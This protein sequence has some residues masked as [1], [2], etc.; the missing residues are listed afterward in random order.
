MTEKT[1]KNEHAFK[2]EHAEWQTEIAERHM[3]IERRA[4]Q[5]EETVAAS[6]SMLLAAAMAGRGGGLTAEEKAEARLEKL[7]AENRQFLLTGVPEEKWP[8]PNRA[9][10]LKEQNYE[11]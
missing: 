6:L 4:V 7:R 11:I 3:E 2:K 10:Y 8:S 1:F 5:A 9:L